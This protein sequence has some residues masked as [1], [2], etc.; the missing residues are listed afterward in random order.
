[1]NEK[2]I[3]IPLRLDAETTR[4]LDALCAKQ[5]AS[6]SSLIREFIVAGLKADGYMV[7]DDR[8][9]QTTKAAL[10]EIIEPAISRLAAIGAK[11]AQMA[12]AD[13][14]M[15]TYLAKLLIGQEGASQIDE[16]SERARLAGIELLKA[17]DNRHADILKKAVK[18]TE[19]YI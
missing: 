3:Y 16:M 7:D 19:D 18:E 13:Y 9:Y 10:T 1:M 2:T 14:V 8:I 15:L 5:N 6:R 12:G 4:T 17:K 11:N